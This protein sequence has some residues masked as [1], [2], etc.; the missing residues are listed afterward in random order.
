MKSEESLGSEVSGGVGGEWEWVM[1]DR[2]GRASV[3]CVFELGL[4]ANKYVSVGVACCQM[5]IYKLF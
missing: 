2:F 3:H 4:M 1:G 5:C